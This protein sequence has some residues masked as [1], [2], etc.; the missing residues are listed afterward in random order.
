MKKHD[1]TLEQ[2]LV[3]QSEMRHVEKSL[4][5]AY[6]LLL[7]GHLGVHRF[8]LKRHVSGT[9]QLILFLIAVMCY[10][11]AF[12]MTGDDEDLTAASIFFILIM[13]LAGLVLFI[14][15][16]VDLFLMPRMVR[17]WNE[18]REAEIIRRLTGKS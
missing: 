15:I 3:L 8:Y 16:I 11:L 10:F 17:E 4:G 5:L 12:I 14:W 9:I 2:L 7:G 6:L 18:A 13:L 1:L